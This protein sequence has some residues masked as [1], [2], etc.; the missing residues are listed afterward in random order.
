M[1]APPRG[2]GNP[3]P[4][5]VAPPQRSFSETAHTPPVP[6]AATIVR[7]HLSEESMPSSSKGTQPSLPGQDTSK[8]LKGDASNNALHQHGIASINLS[9][10]AQVAP[11][12]HNSLAVPSSIKQSH[13]TKTGKG[14]S[15]KLHSTNVTTDP[16][17]FTSVD[18]AMGTTFSTPTDPIFTIIAAF[19]CISS[20]N[21]SNADKALALR[22]LDSS[23]R[24][25]QLTALISS[26]P[27]NLIPSLEVSLPPLVF[28][29]SAGIRALA[30]AVSDGLGSQ[31]CP[32]W[33]S[34]VFLLSCFRF[35][36][37]PDTSNL[38]FIAH[39][40]CFLV[41]KCSSSWIEPNLAPCIVHV[42]Q[43]AD[44]LHN[45]HTLLLVIRILVV[46]A[47]AYPVMFKRYMKSVL[48]MLLGWCLDVSIGL[49]SSL[50]ICNVISEFS[51][52][53]SLEHDLIQAAIKKVDLDLQRACI[54]RSVDFR[55]PVLTQ[56][57]CKLH[58]CSDGLIH[59]A[60]FFGTFSAMLASLSLCIDKCGVA[61]QRSICSSLLLLWRNTSLN[62]SFNAAR[63]LAF[64]FLCWEDETMEVSE[65]QLT[66]IA[67]G[68][69]TCDTCEGRNYEIADN[70]PNETS[71]SLLVDPKHFLRTRRIFSNKSIWL[72][73]C[74]HNGR[75]GQ[76]MRTLLISIANAHLSS[77]S[78][79]LEKLEFLECF[80]QLADCSNEN[81]SCHSRITSLQALLYPPTDFSTSPSKLLLGLL[82]S[83]SVY[84]RISHLLLNNIV[85]AACITTL[86][87]SESSFCSENFD[88][89]HS[90]ISLTIL[91][92]DSEVQPDVEIHR[93]VSDTLSL[94]VYTVACTYQSVPAST[95]LDV[96]VSLVS[97]LLQNVE[98]HVT[99]SVAIDVF[100][101]S[102]RRLL[103]EQLV[104][105]ISQ[106]KLSEYL[107]KNTSMNKFPDRFHSRSIDHSVVSALL[108]LLEKSSLQKMSIA[109]MDAILLLLLQ[110]CDG[111]GALAVAAVSKQLLF[112]GIFHSGYM[113]S[114]SANHSEGA[115]KSPRVALLRRVFAAVG[116]MSAIDG[117]SCID[118]VSLISERTPIALL[119][120]IWT[121]SSFSFCDLS[122]SDIAVL[123]CDSLMYASFGFG[124]NDV[125]SFSTME[126]AMFEDSHETKFA[127][128]LSS[129]QIKMFM[130]YLS[131]SPEMSTPKLP[132]SLLSHSQKPL[133][134]EIFNN[135]SN[136]VRCIGTLSFQAASAI[137][138]SRFRGTWGGAKE[139]F[140]WLTVVSQF[141]GDQLPRCLQQQ[142]IS[143]L[144]CDI[145]R[146]SCAASKPVL[147]SQGA[148][149]DANNLYFSQNYR[150]IENHC[151]RARA[152]ILERFQ[153]LSPYDFHEHFKE[154]L[155]IIVRSAASAV[156]KRN[157][158]AATSSCPSHFQIASRHSNTVTSGSLSSSETAIQDLESLV[159]LA[160]YFSLR[161][162]SPDFCV[163]LMFAARA[164]AARIAGVSSN[165]FNWTH[166]VSLI[167][168]GSYESAFDACIDQLQHNCSAS[169]R[170]LLIDC[171]C[172]C[173]TRLLN[174]SLFLRLDS[175][176]NEVERSNSSTYA[177]ASAAC[178]ALS[179]WDTSFGVLQIFRSSNSDIF[180]RP[181]AASG[182]SLGLM[183]CISASVV[184]P[185][186][187]VKEI[188]NLSVAISVS[189]A[190]SPNHIFS[191]S[192]S[193]MSDMTLL[194]MIDSR[195]VPV[196]FG[197]FSH[198]NLWAL[199]LA[200]SAMLSLRV[201]QKFSPIAAA[202]KFVK[203]LR[204]HGSH[205]SAINFM[206]KANLLYPSRPEFFIEHF[207]CICA[208]GGHAVIE[209]LTTTMSV[210]SE[211]RKHQPELSIKAAFFVNDHLLCCDRSTLAEC[212]QICRREPCGL[213]SDSIRS[214]L[215]LS[216]NQQF[217]LN[218]I[219]SSIADFHSTFNN[220]LPSTVDAALSVSKYLTKLW[221]LLGTA[222]FRMTSSIYNFTGNASIQ[223]D[224]CLL[225]FT[226]SQMP[227]FSQ[228]S[229]REIMAAAIYAQNLWIAQVGN[230]F[231]HAIQPR[232]AN[233]VE[234]CLRSA[235]EK[236]QR[237]SIIS[238]VSID[239]IFTCW[240][241]VY[242]HQQQLSS[243]AAKSFLSCLRCNVAREST[244][245]DVVLRLLRI[246]GCYS[247]GLDHVLQDGLSTS[248]PMCWVRVLPQLVAQFSH[249]SD[250]FA[251]F[252]GSL[253]SNIAREYPNRVLY[254]AVCSVGLDAS[255]PVTS[256]REWRV[257]LKELEKQ[258][259]HAVTSIRKMASEL[260]LLSVLPEEKLLASI[261]E[262]VSQ[263]SLKIQQYTKEVEHVTV[264]G[265]VS[266][267]V[268]TQRYLTVFRPLLISLETALQTFVSDC[269]NDE[270]VLSPHQIW[271]N[272]NVLPS[273]RIAVESASSPIFLS[274]IS[275]NW[276]PLRSV[277][278]KIQ[279]LIRRRA[280]ID[281]L[282]MSSVLSGDFFASNRLP[283][284]PTSSNIWINHSDSFISGI[285]P[286]I[287]VMRTKTL[288]KK[289]VFQSSMGNSKNF[290]LK[291]REDLNLD[292]R[293]MQFVDVANIFF[294]ERLPV[295]SRDFVKARK[296]CVTPLSKRAGLIE[297]ISNCSSLMQLYEA[298]VSARA[299]AE[300][301]AVA[302]SSEQM[303]QSDAR[304]SAPFKPIDH[305]I[306]QLQKALS[307][308]GINFKTIPR[309]QWPKEVMLKL[310]RQMA[311]SAPR[312]VFHDALWSSSNSSLQWWT[313]HVTFSRS[314]AV[315]SMIGYIIGLG[316]RHLDNILLDLRDG[317][318]LHIDWNVCF[319]KGLRLAIPETVPF[320]LT[321]GLQYALGPGGA[322]GVFSSVATQCME[323][324]RNNRDILM[325]LLETF[326]HDP[327]L[328]WATALRTRR[329]RNALEVSVNFSLLS[330]RLDELVDAAQI[331]ELPSVRIETS[332]HFE[333]KGSACKCANQAEDAKLD[334]SLATYTV[335][336]AA[337]EV[338][339]RQSRL[340][341]LK[342]LAG[343]YS[344][345][346]APEKSKASTRV[347][348][349]EFVRLINIQESKVEMY[350]EFFTSLKHPSTMKIIHNCLNM[351]RPSFSEHPPTLS[352]WRI[353]KVNNSVK[354]LT[355]TEW[356][357]LVALSHQA[358]TNLDSAVK[359]LR[360]FILKYIDI[361]MPFPP[362][363]YARMTFAGDLSQLGRAV[364]S[365]QDNLDGRSAILAFSSFTCNAL[366]QTRN[367]VFRYLEKFHEQISL[368]SEQAS[369]HLKVLEHSPRI[370]KRVSMPLDHVDTLLN[371]LR[372]VI[373]THPF[374][375]LFTTVGFLKQSITESCRNFPSLS[376]FSINSKTSDCGWF[377]IV[378]QLYIPVVLTW[379]A[380]DSNS[381][382]AYLH[383]QSSM[384]LPY[385]CCTFCHGLQ[386]SSLFEA[387]RDQEL[388]DAAFLVC[389]AWNIV[390]SSWLCSFSLSSQL[391]Q[392]F[393]SNAIAIPE[394]EN[395]VAAI[396]VFSESDV[397]HDTWLSFLRSHSENAVASV[398]ILQTISAIYGWCSPL[399]DWF[400][401]LHQ[402]ECLRSWLTCLVDLF[403][404]MFR[405]TGSDAFIIRVC[406]VEET[407]HAWSLKWI[408]L[409]FDDDNLFKR[410]SCLP[411]ATAESLEQPSDICKAIDADF[412]NR[413]NLS[414]AK[415][416]QSRK[417]EV[418]HHLQHQQ[419]LFRQYIWTHAPIIQLKSLPFCPADMK[420][421]ESGL[422]VS[423]HHVQTCLAS[424]LSA[425]MNITSREDCVLQSHTGKQPEV[426]QRREVVA[427]IKDN[428]TALLILSQKVI[429][430]EQQRCHCH[431][432]LNWFG[433][434]AGKVHSSVSQF[435]NTL[436]SWEAASV[437]SSCGVARVQEACEI[438]TRALA[439]SEDAAALA[440]SELTSSEEAVARA[441]DINSALRRAEPILSSLLRLL[442][443]P[444]TDLLLPSDALSDIRQL[445]NDILD[446]DLR[447]DQVDIVLKKL[448]STQQAVSQAAASLNDKDEIDEVQPN[449]EGATLAVKALRR[450]QKKLG[451]RDLV[452]SGL[453][454]K[455][456][457][458]RAI[459]SA[460][461]VHLLARM[462]EGWTPWI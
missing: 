354:P 5:Y 23:I 445:I 12:K 284:P 32:G 310:Y 248:P 183:S 448:C 2:R 236:N 356:M 185:S 282:S 235:A 395:F 340:F 330:A 197:L 126:N 261:A 148:P 154:R 365:E 283:M 76:L 170:T 335:S 370:E 127:S 88:I 281:L 344:A 432:S 138:A 73:Q 141:R 71:Y 449:H 140:D 348:R 208:A 279:E 118:K 342:N 280:S 114:K 336:A 9:R 320:R 405:H 171:A 304:Q 102:D 378:Q 65:D 324:L 195:Q 191:V 397:S 256:S 28:S 64:W 268:Q 100:H 159:I 346:L 381:A 369:V 50:Q 103:D 15:S 75:V 86:D 96:A 216:H 215:P 130:T 163:C 29:G 107:K 134:R 10:S 69:L 196:N 19:S 372:E 227:E 338:C 343:S 451:G 332:A 296:Y 221:F 187:A 229:D 37:T 404:Q 387:I 458:E 259:P 137:I 204:K 399:I 239:L 84:A 318:I 303:K 205:T 319:E 217:L 155:K 63:I 425:N 8:N 35:L 30:L 250:R 262:I 92:R 70:K 339:L 435:L 460:T 165:I 311:E 407:F 429:D 101:S 128:A 366:L 389:K 359:E 258:Q 410:L 190:S 152:G 210:A 99:S 286:C 442:A 228:L 192:K 94:I 323:V 287:L 62:Q 362:A 46:V 301:A 440:T 109:T 302:A 203:T 54:L 133:P 290:L 121:L 361:V 422:P 462:Y 263:L 392:Q 269:S 353:K 293:M 218:S 312:S 82:S 7:T 162:M 321:P 306:Q 91:L 374:E 85:S 420:D 328:D 176:L 447:G 238:H 350:L 193:L 461:N 45:S 31:K 315:S 223:E 97:Y 56:L 275:D 60:G 277:G 421:L 380:V 430:L 341:A 285:E 119:S 456:Q 74:T 147:G 20:S 231:Y 83:T 391:A 111:F 47:S 55:V 423:V 379:L 232:S 398:H 89:V 266:S 309:N 6:R 90:S 144:V 443:H 260:L 194:N 59:A 364:V 112:V 386:L 11:L 58:E 271:L 3:R 272:R 142:L 270:S 289:M 406:F 436:A 4:L 93:I 124:S 17:G 337:T 388:C 409:L 166:A 316:D 334:L 411:L 305:Y 428:V 383:N 390:S 95:A 439:A 327:L 351:S 243:L 254:T 457:V 434:S 371:S 384:Q 329:K 98:D 454:A 38:H 123:F 295:E 87:Y 225:K 251:A 376:Q 160:A 375:A 189:L 78:S 43:L 113:S 212:S 117:D 438:T 333:G 400:L 418:E 164:S 161:L 110:C 72:L 68:C 201:E 122:L 105:A 450:I 297:W 424:F 214:A 188:S 427:N 120:C 40:L 209:T 363:T 298:G 57:F 180:D 21:S 14:R 115:G 179:S 181:Q 416:Y 313:R 79:R 413:V 257:V 169:L 211:L 308:L 446:R 349:Q 455:A 48:K 67:N 355:E 352:S 385:P 325:T 299:A 52:V 292:E 213:L 219:A 22:E 1:S 42:Q 77:C 276:K 453:S 198:A 116:N 222:A 153:Y 13:V 441:E 452:E 41:S 291:G 53:L 288:P 156:D 294:Q 200:Q 129:D 145:H 36:E 143:S 175:I 433:S 377:C 300:V 184:D 199:T 61:S 273:L 419:Q 274:D 178:S 157:A 233:E 426:L 24:S 246:I 136:Y 382:V 168:L 393:S 241:K 255:D 253:L 278:Q 403:S 146:L 412:C 368:V 402:A 131:Q 252:A 108:L 345:R 167:C 149:L 417:R 39:C 459:D 34:D 16:I 415:L 267:D 245:L 26:L 367:D 265:N 230:R 358:F 135:L 408:Q 264:V 177:L 81:G 234:V 174:D 347:C 414:Y 401:S 158:S 396:A 51:P 373:E 242:V 437:F 322:E 314:L 172:T 186:F 66:L 125:E 331:K 249:S 360:D 104:S 431:I 220:P 33:N 139:F 357:R 132:C 173:V 106:A 307:D 80:A 25:S 206:K 44:N 240:K 244:Q 237:D 326:V 151:L 182:F 27:S 202:L 247:A 224:E 226:G 317:S 394:I 18:S 444:T 150:T 207:R 49:E